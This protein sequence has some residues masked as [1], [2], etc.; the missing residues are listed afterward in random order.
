[1][2]SILSYVIIYE[3]NDFD[4]FYLITSRLPLRRTTYSRVVT[5]IEIRTPASDQIASDQ[6]QPE[7]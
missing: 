1:M 7:T 3:V 4:I 5:G 2:I 6:I